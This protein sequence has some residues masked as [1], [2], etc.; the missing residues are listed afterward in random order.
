MSRSEPRPPGLVV[1]LDGP[2][3]VGKTTTLAALQRAWPRV[4]AGPL[5]D[6][7]LETC[8]RSFGPAAARW[9]ELIIRERTRAPG[10][11]SPPHWGPLGREL[12]AAMHRAAAV[13][14]HAGFDV[15]VEHV[16]LDRA[17]A[18][19]LAA[20]LEA[21]PVIHIGLTCDPDVLEDREAEAEGGAS[22]R[23]VAELEATA[24]AAVRDR[25]FDT[26]EMTTDELVEAIVEVVEAH[27]R[28]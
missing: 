2:S 19:D 18:E 4:R 11:A 6:V 7:G 20:S 14:A 26:T 8:L 13:W 21:V 17:T 24:A 15:A 25:V 28:G 27:Q 1:V 5:L 22:D 9:R 3:Y 23:A 12:V 10:D 16:L